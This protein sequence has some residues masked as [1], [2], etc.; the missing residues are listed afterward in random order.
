MGKTPSPLL[1]RSFPPPVLLNWSSWLVPLSRL[2][3]HF[4][5]ILPFSS[6][7]FLLVSLLFIL[8]TLFT[9]HMMRWPHCFSFFISSFTPRLSTAKRTSSMTVKTK[10]VNIIPTH[11]G[12]WL[13]PWKEDNDS[14][15]KTSAKTASVKDDMHQLRWGDKMHLKNEIHQF[16]IVPVF[17]LSPFTW[18]GDFPYHLKAPRSK[19][20]MM[21][22]NSHQTQSQSLGP[23]ISHCNCH[24]W[25]NQAFP[26][27]CTMTNMSSFEDPQSKSL[28]T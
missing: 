13:S 4:F 9:V 15:H 11:T 20:L 28:F 16:T 19:Y 7:P 6:I 22:R 23:M 25:Y 14:H 3:S 5:F 26:M 1:C 8:F 2:L 18:D 24:K 12:S 10:F 27:T 17:K 21:Y